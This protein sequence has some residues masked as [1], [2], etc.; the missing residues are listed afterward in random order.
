MLAAGTIAGV[1][2]VV[3]KLGFDPPGTPT[4]VTKLNVGI[5]E[6]ASFDAA[7][8]TVTEA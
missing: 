3:V 8:I 6:R 2:G 1:D 5:R 7:R 4:P